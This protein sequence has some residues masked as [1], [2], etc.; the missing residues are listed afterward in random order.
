MRIKAQEG[1]AEVEYTIIDIYPPYLAEIKCCVC[2]TE[3]INKWGLP[4]SSDTVEIVANDYNGEWGMRS[5]CYNCWKDHD[6]GLLV[7]ITPKF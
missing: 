4:V 2:G 6:N 7:G 1:V 3:T 5:A